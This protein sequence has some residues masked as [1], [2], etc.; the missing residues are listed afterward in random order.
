MQQPDTTKDKPLQ[1]GLLRLVY[2]LAA[3][4][5]MVTSYDFGKLIG[6][7]IVGVLLAL[8]GAI[9]CS[10]VAGALA[11]KLC[12]GWPAARPPRRPSATT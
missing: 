3:V 1:R 12:R 4:A 8:N 6:G 11:E 5:G 10:I 7:P 2:V 9:F